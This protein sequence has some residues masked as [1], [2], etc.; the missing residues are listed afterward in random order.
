MIGLL[1]P[2]AIDYHLVRAIKIHWV[3]DGEML[4][5]LFRDGG[6]IGSFGSRVRV[7]FAMDLYSAETYRDLLRVN[8]IRN[9]FAH[10]PDRFEAIRSLVGRRHL[11]PDCSGGAADI[12][13][14][15]MW[16]RCRCI[17]TSGGQYAGIAGSSRS[18]RGFRSRFALGRSSRNLLARQQ[19]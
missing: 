10:K 1:A 9:L 2:I 12:G 8:K 3:D 4:D 15:A 13:W 5:E 19:A 11:Q 18:C 7:G 16:R 6:P 17:F 14:V